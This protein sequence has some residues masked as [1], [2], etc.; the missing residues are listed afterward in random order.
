MHSIGLIGHVTYNFVTKGDPV[1][2]PDNVTGIMITGFGFTDA[3]SALRVVVDCN[4]GQMSV[5]PDGSQLHIT[6]SCAVGCKPQLSKLITN[7]EDVDI[8][9]LIPTVDFEPFTRP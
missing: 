5:Q 7:Y 6:T 1:P 3:T 2:L 9:N 8:I 4:G